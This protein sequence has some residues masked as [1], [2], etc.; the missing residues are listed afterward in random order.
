M[1]EPKDEF[2]IFQSYIGEGRRSNYSRWN[3]VEIY[4]GVTCS[5]A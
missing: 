3:L 4:G 5:K 1:N 2:A